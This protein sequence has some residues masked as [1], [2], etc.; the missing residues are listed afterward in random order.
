MTSKPPPSASMR[1]AEPSGTGKYLA[2]MALLGAGLVGLLVWKHSEAGPEIRVVPAPSAT[3][4]AT[5]PIDTVDIPPP[6][7]LPPPVPEA[8]VTKV[9]ST[10]GAGGNGCEQTACSG[11]A[12]DDLRKTLSTR[13]RAAHRCYDEALAQDS[14]LKGQV[15]INVRV[16]YNGTVCA[17]SVASSELSNPAVGA[18]IANRFRTGARLAPPAGGCVD[19]NVPIALLPP[20]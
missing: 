6:P 9:V 12:T 19:V 3:G 4:V 18:C 10:G 17:A 14:S 16:G 13:A 20:H 5:R 2:F 7:P 11:S 15:V 1:P 8:G